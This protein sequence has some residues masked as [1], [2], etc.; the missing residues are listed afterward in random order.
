MRD[1]VDTLLR[2]ITRKTIP[3]GDVVLRDQTDLST[4]PLRAELFSVDQLA[5]HAQEIAGWYSVETRK[6]G[7]DRLLPRLIENETVL[8]ETY[9]LISAAVEVN[10]RIAPAGEWLLDN[11]Y[12]VEEQIRTARRH[13]PKGYS[14]ELPHLMKGPLKGYPRV[15][16]IARELI[17]HV[18][19]RV[20]TASLSGFIEAYQNVT[21][22]LIGELWAVPI[23]LRLSLIENLRRV[24]DRIA[25]NRR[26]SDVASY[27]ADRIVKTVETDPKCLIQVVAEMASSDPPMT[28]AFVAE[29]ARRLQGWSAAL[30]FPLTWIEQRLSEMNMTIEQMV[31]AESQSQAAD[32]VSIGNSINSFRLLDAMDWREFVERM[33]VVERTLRE[34]PADEYGDMDFA[35]RDRY[36]HVVEAIAKES[37]IAEEKVAL[38]AMELALD[39]RIQHGGAGRAS[40][41]GYY[42]IDEGRPSLL[43]ALSVP[44]SIGDR[45]RAFGYA[46]SLGLYLGGIALITGSI[47]LLGYRFTSPL[48]F[49]IDLLALLLLLIPASQAGVTLINWLVTL[50]VNPVLLPRMDFSDGIPFEMR[51]LVVIPTVLAEPGDVDDL[52]ESLEVRYLA[53]RDKN[54]YFALLTDLVT[55]KEETLP[56]DEAMVLR[57]GQGIE[58]LNER[59]REEKA[60]TFF[61][62]HRP[63]TW[64]PVEGEWMG[65]ERKRGIIS[66]L[67][68]LLRE[69]MIDEFSVIIG[70]QS[71]LSGVKYVITLDTDTQLPRDMARQMVGTMAH[72]LNQPVIDPMTKSVCDG[73]SLLQPRVGL[74]LPDIGLSRFVRYFGGEPGIDPYTR[75][76]SDV[77]QDLFFEGSFIGKGIYD[78]DIFAQ[79]A[80][81]RFPENLIL[82]HDLLEGCYARTGLVSDL[83]VFEEY[84]ARY[85][86]DIKRRHRWI[87]GDWQIAPWVLSKVPGPDGVKVKNS[88]SLL[89]RWKIFDNLRRSIV[90]PAMLLL[91]VISWAFLPQ[92]WTWLIIGVYLVPP[93]LMYLWRVVRKSPDQSLPFHLREVLSSLPVQFAVPV[94]SLALLPYEAFISLDAVLRTWWRMLISHRCLLNWTTYREADRSGQSDLIGSYYTMWTAP[95]VAVLSLSGLVLFRPSA[96]MSAGLFVVA[97]IASPGLA[98]W[99]SQ[100]IPTKT[101]AL[102]PDQMLFLRAIS[103]RTWRFFETFVTA[104]E[105]WLPPDN[106]QEEPIAVIAHRTSPTDIGLSLLAD[107]GAYDSGYISAR[108]LVERTGKTLQTMAGMK[109]FRGHFY[110][111]YDTVTLEPLLPLYISTVDSGNLTAH[112]LILR[113]GLSDLSEAPVV[114][115]MAFEGIADT[116]ALLNEAVLA[117]VKAEA[118]AVSDETRAWIA[119]IDVACT[120][121]PKTLHEVWQGLVVLRDLSSKVAGDLRS[122]SDDEIRWWAQAVEQ[123]VHDHLEDLKSLASWVTVELPR[124][125]P[126]IAPFPEYQEIWDRILNLKESIPTLAEVTDLEE[127]LLG[128]LDTLLSR[129]L[130]L[131]PGG[132]GVSDETRSWLLSLRKKIQSSSEEVGERLKL[133]DNLIALCTNFSGIEY[134]FLYDRTSELLSIGYNATDLRRDASSYDLLASEARLASYVAIAQGSLPQEH[135]FALGR[136][137]TAGSTGEPILLSWS[138]SMFEY[139][140]PLLVMPT[141]ENT[142]LD[143]TYHAMVAR[144]IEYGRR[145]GVPWGVS[146]SGYNITDANLNYQYRAFGVPGLGF[147]RGLAEDLVITPYASAMALM[148]DP[149][150]ACQNLEQL[151]LSGFVGQYGFYEAIDFTPSRVSPG[152]SYAVVRSYMVH[153]QGMTLLSLL[154]LRGRPM[155]RRFEAEPLLKAT[156][157]LLQEKVPKVAP[158]YPHAGEVQGIHKMLGEPESMMRVYTTPN[159]P[160][161]EVQLLSNGRYHVMVNNAGAGYSRWKDLAVTRW[162]EDPTADCAGTFCYVR[163]VESGVFWSTAFQPACRPT[164]SYQAIFQQPRAEFRRRD[165]DID[166][167]VEVIV[168]PEDDVELRRVRITNRSWRRRTIE[169]TS[170]AEVVLAPQGADESHPAFS[171]LFVQTELVRSRNGILATRRPR[172][173][174]EHPPWLFHM[175]TLHGT[176]SVRKISYETDRAR[177]IGRGRTLRDPVAM[178]DSSTLS[179]TAGSVLDPVVAIRCT[180]TIEPQETAVVNIFTG[181]SETRVGA[182]GLIEKYYD[183]YI[184]ERVA[185]LAWTHAQVVLRQLNAT[186]SQARDFASLAASVVYANPTRRAS[187]EVLI[188]NRRGQSG[189]WGYGISGDYPIVLVRIRDRSGLALV[190]EMVQAH[191]YWR[192]KGLMVDLVIWNEDQSGYRQ[193]LQDEIHRQMAGSPDIQ[194]I[195]RPGGIFV[196]RLEQMSDED[197]VLMQTVARVIIT[198]RGGSL[199]EQMER[200]GWSDLAVPPLIPVKTW[201]PERPSLLADAED[202]L[203]FFNGYGG[204]TEDGHE[205][206]I[207]SGAGKETPAPWV[208]VLAN[209][210]FGTVISESGGSYTW[211]ENAHEFRLTPWYNDP[212]RDL[213][214]EALYIRDEETGR[215]WSPTPLPA[216]GTHQYLTRHG[217]GYSVFEYAESGIHTKLTVFVPVDSSV[218]FLV[219]K[220]RNTSGRVRA[221]SVTGYVEWVLGELR[222]R[223]LL[224]VTTEID[225][226]SGALF[227]RNPYNNEFPDRVAFFDANELNRTVTGDRHEFLGRNGTPA[228]PAAM[229]RARLSGKVGPGLDPCAAIQVPFSLADGQEHEIVFM[230]GVGHDL[231]AARNLIQRY[232]GVGPARTELEAVRQ[233][234]TWTLGAVHISTPDPSVDLLAN[235]WLMY[236]TLACRIWGRTGFYQSGGAFGFRDQLQDVMPILHAEPR[237]ARKHLLLCAGHQ[238]VEGD[239]QHWWHPPMDRGVRTHCSDDYLWLPLVTCRYVLGTRDTGVLNERIPFLEGRP[240]KP[241]EES[242]YDLPR[243]SPESGTLY[244]HCV[245][246]IRWGLKFGSHGLPLIGS[247]DWNDGMNLVG[248]HGQ[249][250]SVWLGF[251]LYDVLFQFAE[252]A[253]IREDTEF[254]DLCMV[255]AERLRQNLEQNGWDGRWYRRAY[256]DSGEPLGSNQNQECFIDSIAQS[257]SVLSGAGD[258]ERVRTAMESVEEHLVRHQDRLIALLTPPFDKSTPNPGY[259]KGYV[260]GVRENGGQYTH[261]AIWVVMAF[262][263]LGDQRRSWD[264]FN[265]INPINHSSTPEDA[266]RYRVEPYVAAADVYAVEPHIGRGGWTWYT[267]SAGWMYRLILESLLGVRLEVDTL[268]FSPCIPVGWS[269]FTMDYRFHETVHHIVIT[270]TGTACGVR[271]VT[272]DGLLQPDR[273]VRLVNDHREHMVEVVLG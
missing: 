97:W 134:E 233:Y 115:N 225:P 87:R 133:V 181:V 231:D 261:A 262:A 194:Q 217:F 169:L 166:T 177:F 205:Y 79:S 245:R 240:L 89:S 174:G 105:H 267:G 199:A 106:Y 2:A 8:L 175:M 92:V 104:N 152:Q 61:L 143:R 247:G 260:P 253:R 113:Q 54:L 41:V 30:A 165:P 202:G 154:Y 55:A 221:L 126:T 252:V 28:S 163:D 137:L 15:Y 187:P 9:E 117:A 116:L 198:D 180:I 158:F 179:D 173:D 251:F 214:G 265:L 188:Q 52:L 185:E 47:V 232:R 120:V 46:H 98:W 3:V 244:E 220:I 88:L 226:I 34:N 236:Q 48:F 23:M 109:R 140:M 264:L 201:R 76:I 227:A 103:R 135:W 176:T 182:E 24:A 29:L 209:P 33:S 11:F 139:L 83:Q 84:P 19:G 257:W 44:P 42:L 147:K 254:A 203:R 256:F 95:L 85:L 107:L 258:K 67:N 149:R 255:N 14:K 239:V 43:S 68:R 191:A 90:P 259:I 160:R 128:P 266:K 153:H 94:I 1:W 123:Q 248:A 80:E 101:T 183:A 132:E 12:L 170:Y 141:Y 70:D 204:F 172:S 150:A 108:R 40:H 131:S 121:M 77:Y 211:S 230:L 35:T 112:L 216:R 71:L 208:N 192:V 144:Q 26:D 234:W 270:A 124:N 5:Q 39:N 222:Q 249:G 119:E 99:L 82:S 229:G 246:A 4:D 178:T 145:R 146:E 118:G 224:H 22:L 45:C 93:A 186:E 32:Q 49:G 36:R 74:L 269:S 111:W 38:K 223:S 207:I 64:N 171:N 272:V 69:N 215:F 114:S 125:T 73:Y 78:V 197:R 157:L 81:G 7:I 63:R 193:E 238:F 62:M 37:G 25:A 72:P 130:A 129:I 50:L 66:A 212:V 17:A 196:R 21:P 210:I 10:R 102:T 218:K 151:A 96:L 16:F 13:L 86:T 127:G 136:L 142:L 31:Q 190:R 53:N 213:S 273:T 110:N 237:L 65:Y 235:G 164:S 200:G 241:E 189:L 59:Y 250:E 162:R 268:H 20:D 195:D 155:Q 75:A 57:L 18:D 60:G 58:E 159:T 206:R 51:T 184:G 161:P 148:V 56:G 138:G 219:L 91:L 271:S 6:K 167:H 100:P 168:S 122:H 243:V 156:S 242:Y 263:A 27:W 228:A